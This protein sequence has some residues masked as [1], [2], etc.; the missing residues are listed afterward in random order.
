MKAI[1]GGKDAQSVG[2]SRAYFP[3][4]KIANNGFKIVNGWLLGLGGEEILPLLFIK[5]N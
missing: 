1:L 4:F 3:D 5:M 2:N